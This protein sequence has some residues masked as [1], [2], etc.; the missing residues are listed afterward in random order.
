MGGRFRQSC[1]TRSELPAKTLDDALAIVRPFVGPV[2][3]GT[4]VG[5]WDPELGAWVP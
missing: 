1:T 5:T 3:D 4:A 2:L